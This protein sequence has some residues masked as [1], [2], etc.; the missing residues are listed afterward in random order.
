[1]LM[2]SNNR[3]NLKFIFY[4]LIL[5]NCCRR[6]TVQIISKFNSFF[7]TQHNKNKTETR[8]K[9]NQTRQKQNGNTTEITFFVTWGFVFVVFLLWFLWCFCFFCCVLVVF[10]LVKLLNIGMICTVLYRIRSV[11]FGPY[12]SRTESKFWSKLTS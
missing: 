9:Q 11:N 8:Q 2:W 3:N 1:M 10:W 7:T 4:A 6:R 5:S 12:I